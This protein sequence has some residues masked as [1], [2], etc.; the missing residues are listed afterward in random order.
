MPGM[1]HR[2]RRGG[3]QGCCAHKVPT[4]LG[5]TGRMPNA[6]IVVHIRVRTDVMPGG[7]P[8]VRTCAAVTQGIALPADEHRQSDMLERDAVLVALRLV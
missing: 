1:M 2:E 8:S 5:G 7:R 6:C 4:E 3:S